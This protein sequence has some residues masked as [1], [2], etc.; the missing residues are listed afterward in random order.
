MKIANVIEL[1]RGLVF[2]V[3]VTGRS[4]LHVVEPSVIRPE[5]EIGEQR[6]QAPSRPAR[7]FGL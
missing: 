7:S 2:I 5:L 6:L 3:P 4:V 1:N